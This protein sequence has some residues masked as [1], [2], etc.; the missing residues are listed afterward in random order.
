MYDKKKDINY[1]GQPTK[2]NSMKG[3]LDCVMFFIS[4]SAQSKNAESVSHDYYLN[5]KELVLPLLFIYLI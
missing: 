2:A 3:L 5:K 1:F 4:A